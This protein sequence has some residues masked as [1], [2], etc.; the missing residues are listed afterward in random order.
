VCGDWDERCRLVDELTAAVTSDSVLQ[1][2]C[3]E[4]QSGIQS[5]ISHGCVTYGLLAFLLQ[6]FSL[7]VRDPARAD[8]VVYE[9]S[10]LQLLQRLL[11]GGV[12]VAARLRLFLQTPLETWLRVVTHVP[13]LATKAQ[14]TDAWHIARDELTNVQAALVLDLQ[15]LQQEAALLDPTNV[16]RDALAQ[17]LITEDAAFDEWIARVVKRLAV[18]VSR[19]PQ[20]LD[21]AERSCSS[22]GSHWSLS[23][24]RATK[25]VRRMLRLSS[26]QSDARPLAQMLLRRRRD[27]IEYVQ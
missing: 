25:V 16:Q 2:L 22:G 15:L 12:S 5:G 14:R 9:L 17:A 1:R 19:T 3:F 11:F 18:L 4:D 23:L 20:Q 27:H 21:A 26:A 8:C 6:E 24:W 7:L 10:L 13:T